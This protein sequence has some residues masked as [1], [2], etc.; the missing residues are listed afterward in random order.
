MLTTHCSKKT[1]LCWCAPPNSL[2]TPSTALRWT[3]KNSP[4]RMAS[5]LVCEINISFLL[6]KNSFL[7]NFVALIGCCLAIKALKIKN[8]NCHPRS[9]DVSSETATNFSQVLQTSYSRCVSMLGTMSQCDDVQVQVCTHVSR[10][11][12]VAAAFEEC[13][14]KFMQDRTV[15]R[16]LCRILNYSHLPH[17]CSVGSCLRWTL[18]VS[19]FIVQWVTVIETAWSVKKL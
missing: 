7:K 17:L 19:S 12:T 15:V 5:K 8:N 6:C 3:R 10:C 9:R 16:D 2:T 13:R 18:F 4:G 14:E 1:N 11:Y